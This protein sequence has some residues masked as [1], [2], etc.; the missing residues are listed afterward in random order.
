MKDGLAGARA[1]VEHGAVAILDP[2]LAGNFGGYQ[3]AVADQV[4]IFRLGFFQVDYVPL[5]DNEDMRG[6]LRI[7]VLEGEGA[8]VFVH[9]LRR[10]SSRYDVAKQTICHKSSW[11][12]HKAQVSDAKC[13]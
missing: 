1:Y 6:R 12:M 10:D 2:A 5:G 9:F 8:L 13:R 7:D 3:L 4:G 11:A